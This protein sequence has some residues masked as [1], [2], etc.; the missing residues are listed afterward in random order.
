M[1]D[2]LTFVHQSISFGDA[3]KQKVVYEIQPEVFLN[4]V[5]YDVLKDMKLRTHRE[6]D[7]FDVA[8]M[9]EIRNSKK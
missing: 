7:M 3:E 4:I 5:P 6:K 8:R 1:I 9:E 2:V